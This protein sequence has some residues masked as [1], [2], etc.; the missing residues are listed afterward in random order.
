MDVEPA[1][2]PHP[3]VAQV[4]ERLVRYEVAVRSMIIILGALTWTYVTASFVEVIVNTDPDGTELRNRMEDLN[5]YIASAKIPPSMAYRL[6]EYLERTKHVSASN[7][8]LRVLAML[9]SK[10]QG[11]VALHANACW[12]KQVPIFKQCEETGGG[13]SFL[14]EVALQLSPFVFAP[15]EWLPSH[16]LYV[17]QRGMVVFNGS[18]LGSGRVWGLESMTH[19]KHLPR[20]PAR[21]LTYSEVNAIDALQ[22]RSL[23]EECDPRSATRI[24]WYVAKEALVAYLIRQLRDRNASVASAPS[25]GAAGSVRTLS[26]RASNLGLVQFADAD[27][28]EGVRR[29]R[30]SAAPAPA[31]AP[32]PADGSAELRAEMHAVRD[33]L[34]AE[35]GEVRG[36]MAALRAQMA[37]VADGVGALLARA[38]QRPAA[39]AV[40]ARVQRRQGASAQ[41]GEASTVG[42]AASVEAS[43]PV[44]LP[45][46]RSADVQST[47]RDLY[48]M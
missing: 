17:L 7:S 39:P 29:K 35:V 25:A 48:R 44:Q 19:S 30:S 22:V 32:A 16:R 26:Q 47:V 41:I 12:L 15:S 8:R 10:L 43:P 46:E 28:P 3:P 31:V 2:G 21:S 11:E 14:T 20:R 36:E 13:R 27:E 37:Q 23:A 40:P 5:R 4:S 1:T 42:V 24:H 6:R 9:S 34:T 38:E 45:A 33:K 18:V